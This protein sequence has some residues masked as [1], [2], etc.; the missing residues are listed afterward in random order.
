MDI[1][2]GKI[3]L[4]AASIAKLLGSCSLPDISA[5]QEDFRIR[6]T[7]LISRIDNIDDVIIGEG[8][9][10]RDLLPEMNEDQINIE[11]KVEDFLKKLE[12]PKHADDLSLYKKYLS[13]LRIPGYIV[14]ALEDGNYLDDLEI[15]KY[16]RDILEKKILT[17]S[18]EETDNNEDTEDFFEDIDLPEYDEDIEEYY[19]ED[20]DEYY[21]EEYY[22]DGEDFYDSDD[23]TGLARLQ[24]VLEDKP[25]S[26]EVEQ[27][28]VELYDEIDYAFSVRQGYDPADKDDYLEHYIDTIENINSIEINPNDPTLSENGWGAY[29]NY[30][31]DTIVLGDANTHYLRHEVAHLEE[32]SFRYFG[33]T[34]DLGF[35]LEE[36]FASYK[37]GDS[38]SKTVWMDSYV[39]DVNNFFMQDLYVHNVSGSYPAFE[40]I[41]RSFMMLGLDMEAFRVRGEH[42]PIDN[43]VDDMEDELNLIYGGNRGTEYMNC[44]HEY[45]EFFNTH[46]IVDVERNNRGETASDLRDRMYALRDSMIRSR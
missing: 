44:I 21:D 11:S 28:I 31:T 14:D 7:E 18:G 46:G 9:I 34:E 10:I 37:E 45:I 20:E 25:W 6:G 33:T 41:Y 15:P 43:L 36:G 1:G 24:I 8:L 12:I 17:N 3:M 4:A 40:E 19:P 13:E 38:L 5:V 22:D 39:F 32:G 2:F 30:V 42:T 27:L 26:Y 29:A 35:V 16:I 23:E